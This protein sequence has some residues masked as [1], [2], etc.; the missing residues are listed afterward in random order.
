[1]T[2][3][4]LGSLF[5]FVSCL[6]ATSGCDRSGAPESEQFPEQVG[7]RNVYP[8]PADALEAAMQRRAP[9]EA[10]L[11]IPDSDAVRGEL[12]E[13]QSRSFVAVLRPGLCYKILS[14]GGPGVADLD[15]SLSNPDGVLLQ[16]DGTHHDHPTIGYERA[17]CPQTAGAYRVELT[18]ARGGGTYAAQVWVSQ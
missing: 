13:G 18:M 2:A 14:Q 17:I 7:D 1:M 6:I 16:R 3:R 8:P 9:D 4:R 10:M 11:M 12:A 15:I 5:A